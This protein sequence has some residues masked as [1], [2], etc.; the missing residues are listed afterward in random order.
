MNTRPSPVPASSRWP[1]RVNATLRKSTSAVN[2]SPPGTTRVVSYNWT[3]P[4]SAAVAKRVAVV[5]ERDRPQRSGRPVDDLAVCRLRLEVPSP[6]AVGPDRDQPAPGRIDCRLLDAAVRT[7]ERG[8]SLA[9]VASQSCTVPS[10]A[11]V[12]IVDPSGVTS[13][14]NTSPTGIGSVRDTMWLPE[15]ATRAL[16]IA[17]CASA[18]IGVDARGALGGE[19]QR[20]L[21]LRRRERRG[22]RT[23]RATEAILG[24]GFLVLR[25]TQRE[26]RHRHSRPAPRSR[27]A[28]AR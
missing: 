2:G 28:R 13:A 8:S 3:T 23:E 26:E 14:V 12:T 4:F 17:C 15:S 18:V 10:R 25:L 20:E 22:L 19:Q 9:D 5:R 11:P 6:D 27:A 1:S 24:L 21:R 7:G 16:A